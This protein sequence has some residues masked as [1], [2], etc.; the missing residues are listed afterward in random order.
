MVFID[1]KSVQ[2][3]DGVSSLVPGLKNGEEDALQGARRSVDGEARNLAPP[4]HPHGTGELG[5]FIL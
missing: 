3:R 5:V 4:L 2:V 1:M